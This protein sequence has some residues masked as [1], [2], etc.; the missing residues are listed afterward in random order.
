MSENKQNCPANAMFAKWRRAVD[1]RLYKVYGITIDDAGIDDK[2][3]T[4]HFQSAETPNDFVYWVGE[5]YDLDPKTDY[6]W[7]QR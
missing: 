3:L 2:R 1:I 4:N 7:H 6:L 5:K